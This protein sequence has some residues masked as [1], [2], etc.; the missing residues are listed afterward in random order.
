[1]KVERIGRLFF[2]GGLVLLTAFHLLVIFFREFG[3][4]FYPLVWWSFILTV[5]GYNSQRGRGL[6]LPRKFRFF[7][8]AGG[9]S[10]FLWF[11][12]EAFNLY[13]GN[14]YYVL[15]L[16]GK[17]GRWF[18][19]VLCYATVLPG[20]WG[21]QRLSHD[22]LPA[23][24]DSRVAWRI[25]RWLPPLF[26]LLGLIGVL[27]PLLA[28][29]YLYPFV[30]GGLLFWVEFV[31]YRSGGPTF[32][33]QLSEGNYRPLIAWLIAGGVCGFLWEFWNSFA[34]MGW[35]YTV[36]LFDQLRLF[37][38]PLLGYLGFPPFAVMFWRLYRFITRY[39]RKWAFPSRLFFWLV[40]V[41]F[42]GL[43]L[44]GMDYYTI[45]ST[46]L[47]LSDYRGWTA[48]ERKLI[49][50]QGFDKPADILRAVDKHSPMREKAQLLRYGGLGTEV[51]NCLDS[52]GI[53]SISELR[54]APVEPLAQTLRECLGSRQAF[55]R[56]RIKDWKHRG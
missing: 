48:S 49:E 22:Y 18:G 54:S 55:W 9:I 13:L 16:E 51:A 3:L 36:P 1:M 6:F 33:T 2:A 8:Y 39:Y 31:E 17:I 37:E 4:F 45:A 42:C 19:A 27:G 5:E 11:V 47:D 7:L 23:G 28:P 26:F 30:W 52:V 29:T 43:V 12:F 32:L 46:T 40:F 10:A 21:V 15:A 25:P 14:W 41:L 53:H 24:L 44:V 38:M 34:L 56:R 20:L 50:R 35:I